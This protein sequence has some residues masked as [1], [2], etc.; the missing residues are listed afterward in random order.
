LFDFYFGENGKPKKLF[1]HIEQYINMDHFVVR[2][3]Q[4]YNSKIYLLPAFHP[5]RPKEELYIEED[6]NADDFA[7]LQCCPPVKTG[8]YL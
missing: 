5:F 8:G 7:G 4:E 6:W 2:N 1:L 3:L